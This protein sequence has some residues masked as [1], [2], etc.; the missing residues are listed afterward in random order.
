[1]QTLQEMSHTSQNQ[2]EVILHSPHP[3]P[4]GQDRF[5]QFPSPGPEKLDFSPGRGG[6]MVTGQIE[7]CI[8]LDYNNKLIIKYIL[9]DFEAA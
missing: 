9:P 4:P 8:I 1:M 3:R 2:R 7:Q 6:G 5:K